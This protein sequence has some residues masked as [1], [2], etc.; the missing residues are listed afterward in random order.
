[1]IHASTDNRALLDGA[2]LAAHPDAGPAQKM[3][4]AAIHMAHTPATRVHTW[5]IVVVGMLNA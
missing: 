1:V 5:G 2:R 4:R 3:V